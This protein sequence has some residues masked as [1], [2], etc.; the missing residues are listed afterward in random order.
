MLEWT[1]DSEENNDFFAI[2]HSSNGFDFTDIDH[3]QGAGTG[4]RPQSY[5]YLH[6]GPVIGSNYYRLKQTDFDDAFSYSPV[7]VVEMHRNLYLSVSPTLARSKIEVCVSAEYSGRE[8]IIEIYDLSG[9]QLMSPIF[10]GDNCQ[11]VDVSDLANGQYLVQISSAK[12]S[13]IIRFVK[14]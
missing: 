1:T 9:R 10:N 13:E 11:S 8:G 7:E 4:L 12:T 5:R 14:N 3:I 6:E 2:E